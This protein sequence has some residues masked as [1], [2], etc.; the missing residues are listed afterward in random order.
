MP[1][2]R[3]PTFL[4]ELF[5]IFWAVTL[6]VFLGIFLFMLVKLRGV[7]R[8]RTIFIFYEESPRHLAGVCLCPS[9]ISINRGP[10]LAASRA[11]SVSE[12][13]GASTYSES[14]APKQQ[15]LSEPPAV[16]S[17]KPV[18]YPGFALGLAEISLALLLGGFLAWAAFV[19]WRKDRLKPGT[20]PP[21]PGW[22]RLPRMQW[23]SWR[24]AVKS[25]MLCSVAIGNVSGCS[26][27]GKHQ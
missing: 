14:E 10:D 25:R 22:Y 9:R 27:Q 4:R 19:C 7:K 18:T 3:N 24:E 16:S 13:A 21:E 23:P 8:R 2:F 1:S 26:A 15:S 5:V 20:E 11:T 12:T 17:P 6:A